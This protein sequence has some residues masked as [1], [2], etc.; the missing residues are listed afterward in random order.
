M[1]IEAAL[2]RSA[3][4]ASKVC[5]LS[6][7]IHRADTIESVFLLAQPV[8]NEVGRS[9]P[10]ALQAV[11]LLAQYFGKK[12]DTVSLQSADSYTVIQ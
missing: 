11:K 10:Q 9:S 12:L 1:A 2:N 5:Y 4:H 7:A 8:I 6:H 3:Q